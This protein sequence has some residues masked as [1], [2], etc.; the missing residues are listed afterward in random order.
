MSSHPVPTPF[1]DQTETILEKHLDRDFR[2]FPMADEQCTPAQVDAISK[3]FGIQY[4]SQFVAHICGRFPGIYVEVKE[5]IWPRPKPYDVG[6]FWTFLYAVHTFTPSLDSE[7]WMRL[8]L[9][10]EQFQER[11]GLIAAPIFKVV[12]DANVYCVDQDGKLTSYDHEANALEPVEIGF[13]ELFEREVAALVE[14][15]VRKVNGIY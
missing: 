14:R 12:G 2:V 4:P 11:T 1:V 9:A 15:K 10:A 3:R 7:N 6:P 5:D 13:W 8:D